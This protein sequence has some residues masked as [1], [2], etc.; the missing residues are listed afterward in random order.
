MIF[1]NTKLSKI[2]IGR[3]S[4]YSKGVLRELY[5][6]FNVKFKFNKIENEVYKGVNDNK[7]PE[8]IPDNIIVSCMGCSVYNKN[9][10]EN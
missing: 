4:D 8:S 3:L 2:K 10:V 6:L 7:I 5:S 9:R 1:E